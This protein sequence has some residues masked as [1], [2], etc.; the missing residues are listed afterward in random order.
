MKCPATAKLVF[1]TVIATAGAQQENQTTTV[2]TTVQVS[3]DNDDLLI[4]TTA[5]ELL[6]R[7]AWASALS[8]TLMGWNEDLPS[9]LSSRLPGD[10]SGGAS[11]T[12]LCTKISGELIDEYVTVR[13]GRFGLSW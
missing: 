3:S 13:Q 5:Y 11:I 8:R 10:T 9:Q 12:S 1:F 7:P 2:T 6:I 4:Q